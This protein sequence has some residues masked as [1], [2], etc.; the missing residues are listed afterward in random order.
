MIVGSVFSSAVLTTSAALSPLRLMRMSSGP[1]ARK[2]KPRSGSSNWN[3]ET[4]R[5]STTPLVPSSPLAA[6]QAVQLREFAM[7]QGE[8][9]GIQR[10][11]LFAARDRIGIAVD[12]EHAAI[13]GFED[14]ARITAAAESAVDV[15]GAVARGSASSTSAS[16]TGRWPIRRLPR[17]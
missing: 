9:A 14:G 13:A 12:A 10:H 2:E 15:M 17:R 1:S 8:A 6:K 3:E 5:S 4:P 16:M 11:Q 7:H